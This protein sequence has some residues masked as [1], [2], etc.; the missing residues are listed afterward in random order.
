MLATYDTLEVFNM[1]YGRILYV[2][3]DGYDSYFGLPFPSYICDILHK[4]CIMIGVPYKT[5]YGRLA[6]HRRRMDH[7]IPLQ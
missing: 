1:D 3:L 4:C 7:T 2:L 6:I 5:D